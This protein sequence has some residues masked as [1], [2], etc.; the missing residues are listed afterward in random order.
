MQYASSDPNG[1][2]R[3]CRCVWKVGYHLGSSDVS[4][5][6]YIR[7]PYWLT[8][9]A[10]FFSIS[11]FKT[12]LQFSEEAVGAICDVGCPNGPWRQMPVCLKRL[13]RSTCV[14]RMR[15]QFKIFDILAGSQLLIAK[16][17]RG[18]WRLFEPTDGLGIESILVLRHTYHHHSV[19]VF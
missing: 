8:N 19:M 2:K 14:R 15:V 3:R 4:V 1:P 16:I 7:D 10:Y 6:K 13:S 5:I 12:C 11:L 9:S 18:R 17:H